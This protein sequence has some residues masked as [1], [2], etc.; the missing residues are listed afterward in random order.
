MIQV[1]RDFYLI[2]GYSL[3]PE[4]QFG[5]GLVFLPRESNDAGR[6]EQVLSDIIREEGVDLIGFREVPRDNSTIGE[7]ARSAEPEIKQILLVPIFRRMT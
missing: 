1:P 6:C 5:T 4:G 2:Q 3:P 7:I